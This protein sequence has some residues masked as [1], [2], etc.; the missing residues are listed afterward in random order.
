MR[1][2]DGLMAI[3][4][5]LLAIA[6]VAAL[7]ATIGTVV[8]AIAIPEVPR[9]TRLVRS[10]VLSLREEPFVEAARA[11]ATPTPVILFRHILPNAVSPV[12]VAT[13]LAMGRIML[14]ESGLSF[15]GVGIQPPL[16]SWG[17]MLTNAQELANGLN[18]GD[19]ADAALDSD[20]DGIPNDVEVSLGTDPHKRD[21]DGDGID[22]DVE[23]ALGLDP[24][25]ADSDG[26][27]IPDGD[28]DTDGD[29]LTNLIELAN[30]LNPG[31]S[32]D[33]SLD[34]DGDGKLTPQ[35][36][37]IGL[38]RLPPLLASMRSIAH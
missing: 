24:L 25:N 11:L 32:A 30:G 18:P 35:E 10:L 3:P 21:S 4:A 36:F 34:S 1:F 19:K 37:K 29:G 13:T 8:V 2:M 33:A 38:K 28:E 15:L 23:L 31:G 27:G 12:I 14:T 26:D 17:A 16:T 7:G 5:I 20:G 9:V 6:L 22:D